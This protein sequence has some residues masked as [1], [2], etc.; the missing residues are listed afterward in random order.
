VTDAGIAA[1]AKNAIDRDSSIILSYQQGFLPVMPEMPAPLK[2][3]LR[4]QVYLF[5]GAFLFIDKIRFAENHTSE[6]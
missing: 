6:V 2:R 1:I 4:P 3:S 5:S